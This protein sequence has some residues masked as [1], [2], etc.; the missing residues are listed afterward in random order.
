MDGAA[1]HSGDE[2]CTSQAW[3]AELS[4]E[5]S[6][7]A[8]LALGRGSGPQMQGH[9]AVWGYTSV[10]TT[11]CWELGFGGSMPRMDGEQD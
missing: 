9:K 10:C 1:W 6:R 4:W 11:W 7:A 5:L 8:E 2:I 3:V